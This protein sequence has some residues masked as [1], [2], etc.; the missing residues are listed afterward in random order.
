MYRNIFIAWYCLGVLAL[1][2]ITFF[3]VAAFLEPER[4]EWANGCFGFLGLLGLLPVFVFILF[5]KEQCD[6]RDL[7]FLQ[8][9]LGMGLSYGF[10]ATF[11]TNFLLWFVYR[12]GKLDTIP[13]D[14]L[15]IPSLTGAL[16]AML[17]SSVVLLSFYYKG[18]RGL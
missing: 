3:C 15:W 7:S 17:V 4:P 2:L 5:R 6:E 11:L 10:G 8:R 12:I 13:I 18:E 1:C 9:A 16:L 14:T